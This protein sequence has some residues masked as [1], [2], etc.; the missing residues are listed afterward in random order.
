MFH[1]VSWTAGG[2]ARIRSS[3]VLTHFLVWDGVGA[4][5]TLVGRDDAEDLFTAG[6]QGILVK[7]PKMSEN[8]CKTGK[9][10]NHKA[11]SLIADAC[12]WGV[13]G[14]HKNAELLFRKEKVCHQ[15]WIPSQS[16]T[17][18]LTT[19][20]ISSLVQQVF[21]RI[22][23][24]QMLTLPLGIKLPSLQLHAIFVLFCLLL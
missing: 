21:I 15:C 20:N 5:R 13:E 24:T 19:L 3:C 12:N 11:K 16:E 18:V 22:S 23:I 1:W 17:T 14:G 4:E 9:R 6:L 8:K 10:S 7:T 2:S